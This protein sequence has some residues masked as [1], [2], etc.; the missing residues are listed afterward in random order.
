MKALVKYE[1]G[2]G[3]VDLLEVQEP[4]CGVEQVKI[5]VSYCG[6][7]GTDLHVYHDTF[8]NYPPVILGHEFAGVVVE[9]GKNV[10]AIKCGEKVTVLPASAVMCGE[11]IYCRTGQ[12]MFCS[13]RRGMGHGV[14]GAL[15]RYTLVRHD[16]V[17]RIPD[18]FSLA[19]AA[20]CEPFA[21]AVQATTELTNVRLGDVALIS[22]P[23]P[24]GLMC[25]K[26]LAAEGIKTIVAGL[27][28]DKLRL[29]AA[30][31]MGA[32]LVVNV[33]EQDLMSVVAEETKGRG[34]DVA[35]ECSGAPASI[36]S[37]FEAI[38]RLG[39]YTQVGI[40]G[41]EIALNFD[42][43]LYKQLH[44]VGSLAYSVSTWHRLLKI[45]NQRAIRLDDLITHALPLEGW[46]EAFDLCERKEAIKVLISPG[47]FVSAA[48]KR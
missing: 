41:R 21:C 11:C 27:S 33:N 18:G 30:K 17:Y 15:A 23:G 10:K 42:Q 34:V 5:E 26:I 31:K 43:V 14:N 46:K 35:F 22:G 36:R 12:F 6:V 37:C 2:V 4:T 25:L 19:E 47:A 13:Q 44:V 29:E 3:N 9:T 28:D 48:D 8:K 40:S 1:S 45:L 16:Q 39:S 20:L 7:C 32:S 24:I 38:R